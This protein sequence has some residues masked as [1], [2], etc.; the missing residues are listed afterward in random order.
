M[1]KLALILG[2]LIYSFSN[3][4][5]ADG[6]FKF[7]KASG[8]D[9]YPVVSAFA[10]VQSWKPTEPL[11]PE[12][13]LEQS[14]KSVLGP[15]GSLNESYLYEQSNFK[16]EVLNGRGSPDLIAHDRERIRAMVW[17]LH[18]L[19]ELLEFVQ[20]NAK[21]MTLEQSLD[22]TEFLTYAVYLNPAM[23]WIF[24]IMQNLHGAETPWSGVGLKERL[25]GDE[26]KIINDEIRAFDLA[27][28]EDKI[29]AGIREVLLTMKDKR[30]SRNSPEGKRIHI[31]NAVGKIIFSR[32]AH[33][34]PVSLL[35]AS[36]PKGIRDLDATA[37]FQVDRW[38]LLMEARLAA[39]KASP[40][41]DSISDKQSD[42]IRKLDRELQ[43]RKALDQEILIAREQAEKA[44]GGTAVDLP[45]TDDSEPSSPGVA[46]SR[47]D[48][49]LIPLAD[50]RQLPEVPAVEALPKPDLHKPALA[51]KG[52]GDPIP[53]ADPE[54]SVVPAAPTIS[55][56][57]PRD[58]E[59]AEQWLERMKE[60]KAAKEGGKP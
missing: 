28:W 9:C 4:V 47:N 55:P 49:G 56:N 8:A 46:P 14:T 36:A 33:K 57:A 39:G 3:P 7:G 18:N 41:L 35:M 30:V 52:G 60:K 31:L 53:L 1:K 24:R 45:A 17:S 5:V 40:V 50:E 26:A 23:P 58:G 10:G 37:Q 15:I 16:P 44:L 29:K 32:A 38:K 19:A 43:E 2:F 54:R 25:L 13:L 11:S 48:D 12:K 34:N 6:L 21:N 59:T 51:P 27:K 20:R 42:P 22:A